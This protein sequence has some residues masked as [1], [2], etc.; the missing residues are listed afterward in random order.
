MTTGRDWEDEA[1][2]LA[3][4]ALAD[5]LPTRWFDELWTAGE[6]DEVDVPWDRSAPHP[7]VVEHAAAIPDGHDRKAVVV[8]AGLGADAEHLSDHGWRTVAFDVSPAAM[9]LARARHP[10]SSV[11]Y[12]VADLLELP[13]DLT[14]PFDLVVEVF[15]VQALP[16]SV[17]A[18]AI[19]GVRSLLAPGGVLL[20]VEVVRPDGESPMAGPPWL[21]DR[22]AMTSFAGDDVTFASL[23]PVANPSGPGSRPLW[24]GVLRRDHED[25]GATLAGE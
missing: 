2:R 11:D 6:R 13:S 12:R 8:G 18:A 16:P 4:R 24:V 1:D 17:R 10:E 15:T 25:A 19:R 23:A 3:A 20:V 9:R 14:G 7:V 5:G 22:A 21:L